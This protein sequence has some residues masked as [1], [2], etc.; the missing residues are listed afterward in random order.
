M[1]IVNTPICPKCQ[2]CV[3]IRRFSALDRIGMVLFL[4]LLFPIAIWIYLNPRSLNCAGCCNELSEF[5]L[6]KD[7]K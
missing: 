4:F 6:R 5:P 2:E 7:G 1:L 3:M